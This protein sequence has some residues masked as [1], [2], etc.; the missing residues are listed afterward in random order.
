M[1]EAKKR[2]IILALTA[3][4]VA[5]VFFFAGFGTGYG[6]GKGAND[7]P[8][9]DAPALETSGGLIVSPVE[10][11]PEEGKGIAVVSAEIPR[12]QF[13][14]Y[15]IMPI[16]ETAYTVTATVNG[17]GLTAAQ[18]NVTWSVPAF[19][20]PSSSWASGKN[21]RDYVTTSTNGNQITVSCLKAFGEQIIIKCTSVYNGAASANL[22]L[23]YKQKRGVYIKIGNYN[24]SQEKFTSIFY[25]TFQVEY[26]GVL[27]KEFPWYAKYD[28][29][30]TYSLSDGTVSPDDCVVSSLSM[31]LAAHDGTKQFLT[32]RMSSTYDSSGMGSIECYYYGP[33]GLI[34]NPT[35]SLG[36]TAIATVFGKQASVHDMPGFGYFLSTSGIDYYG[37][38]NAC[39]TMDVDV[40]KDPDSGSGITETFTYK[41]KLPISRSSLSNYQNFVE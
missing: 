10:D 7:A 8:T 4:A 6:T 19:K 35:I 1:N 32:D 24:S 36:D 29:E 41:L 3:V 21:V 37:G 22:S 13:D 27:P 25:E 28:F 34:R 38:L 39:L 18:K 5:V 30:F 40:L 31:T 26:D 15:G 16:A 11:G 20:N 33:R 14:D 17:D 9:A 2:K 23:D 12:E